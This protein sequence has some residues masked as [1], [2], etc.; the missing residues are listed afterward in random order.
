MTVNI[1]VSNEEIFLRMLRSTDFDEFC[2]VPP[3]E[4][5]TN[6]LRLGYD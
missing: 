5:V 6:Y 3:S 4:I 1:T 2:N